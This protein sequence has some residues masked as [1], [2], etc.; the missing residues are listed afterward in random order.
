MDHPDTPTPAAASTSGGGLP[1]DDVS[2]WIRATHQL[3]RVHDN[4]VISTHCSLAC[5]L[6][7]LE[8][9]TLAQKIGPNSPGPLERIRVELID[10]AT[11]EAGAFTVGMTPLNHEPTDIYTWP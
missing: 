3:R 7:A 11:G 9:L 5:G 4:S 6:Q 1:A 10:L 8:E 2:V